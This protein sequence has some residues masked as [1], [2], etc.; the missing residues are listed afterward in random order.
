MPQKNVDA[1][2]CPWMVSFSIVATLRCQT[3]SGPFK[4]G[5][6]FECAPIK[7]SAEVFVR[8]QGAVE[9]VFAGV[10][11][12]GVRYTLAVVNAEVAWFD[13]SRGVDE[14]PPGR[15]L[16]RFDDAENAL[17]VSCMLARRVRFRRVV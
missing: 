2:S 9:L 13:L 6:R 12:E 10:F 7:S 17:E 11:G 4:S 1:V 5:G 16:V 8:E 3:A 15:M 14:S